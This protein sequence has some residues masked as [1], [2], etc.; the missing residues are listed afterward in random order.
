M[1]VIVHV[2]HTNAVLYTVNILLCNT[3]GAYLLITGHSVY[4]WYTMDMLTYSLRHAGPTVTIQLQSIIAFFGQYQILLL[5]KRGTCVNDLS[6]VTAWQWL[7]DEPVTSWFGLRCLNHYRPY[8][9]Y[10]INPRPTQYGIIYPYW[11]SACPSLY[12][13]YSLFSM[14]HRELMLLQVT[15]SVSTSSM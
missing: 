11:F 6:R 9:A 8:T 2:S 3:S 5:A 14:K 1:Y 13:N 4:H 7:G 15:S 10:I 12:I